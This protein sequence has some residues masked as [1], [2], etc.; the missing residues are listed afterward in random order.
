MTLHAMAQL[1]R[2]LLRLAGKGDLTIR[3]V[4][5]QWFVNLRDP[6]TQVGR[7]IVGP[8]LGDVIVQLEQ[9]A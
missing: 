4:D 1:G 9:S 3:N 6:L 7:N 2:S 8:D 5:G